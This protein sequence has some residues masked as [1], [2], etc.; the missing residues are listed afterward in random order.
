[1]EALFGELKRCLRFKQDD[2]AAL[3]ALYQVVVPEFPAVAE[4]VHNYALEQEGARAVLG[5]TAAQTLQVKAQLLDWM[6]QMLSGPWD[7]DYFERRCRIGRMAFRINL[8]EHC[9]VGAMVFVEQ[10]LARI[11]NR[12]FAERTDERDRR[13]DAVRKIL[14]I[15]LSILL[16]AY[17]EVLTTQELRTERLSTIG[18]LVSAIGHE[19]RNPFAI[20][21]SSLFVVRSHAAGDERILKHLHRIGEQLNISTSIVAALL[22]LVSDRPLARSPQKLEGL[23]H[24]V[25]AT[26]VVPPGVQVKIEGVAGLPELQA[27]GMRLRQALRNVLEN[28]LYAAGPNGVVAVQAQERQGTIVL[29]VADS[30]PGVAAEIQKRLFEPLISNKQGGTGL[31]L[32]LAKRFIERH[33]GSITYAPDEKGTRFILKLPVAESA[34]ADG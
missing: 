17:R 9:I 3:R 11:I 20:I 24:E 13:T 4:A 27:D 29:T 22:D 32:P 21:E 14:G 5:D 25:L 33:G 16:Q 2:Q 6:N 18:Q 31:G 19:L 1:M 23:L 10:Q 7:G 12:H 15:E 28:A 30:G 26:L 34:Q 8:P